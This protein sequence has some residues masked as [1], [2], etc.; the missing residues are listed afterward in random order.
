MFRLLGPSL[1]DFV[2]Q[3][4]LELEHLNNLITSGWEEL[5][6]E[7]HRVLPEIHSFDASVKTAEGPMMD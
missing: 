3:D 6:N 2:L 4:E 1:R 7:A 5:S